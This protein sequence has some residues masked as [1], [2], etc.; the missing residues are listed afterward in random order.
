MVLCYNQTALQFKVRAVDYVGN[1]GA[2]L[3]S[4]VTYQF[5]QGYPGYYESLLP[6]FR[7][8][9]TPFPSAPAEPMRQHPVAYPLPANSLHPER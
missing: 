2:W 3:L 5:G 9:V 1:S 7:P 8:H 4:F 6:L